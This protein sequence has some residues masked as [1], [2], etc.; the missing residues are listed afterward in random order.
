MKGRFIPAT[1]P[2]P[3]TP[4]VQLQ[5]R[6]AQRLVALVEGFQAGAGGGAQLTPAIGERNSDPGESFRPAENSEPLNPRD[7]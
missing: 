2:A 3:K 6:A 1:R 4:E 5:I 7:S